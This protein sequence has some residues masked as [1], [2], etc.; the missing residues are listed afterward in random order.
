[1]AE[2]IEHFITAFFVAEMALRFRA[3]GY[4]PREFLRGWTLFD[5]V[6][7]LAA[8][9][10]ALPGGA[11]LRMARLGRA[12]KIVHLLRRFP[13]LR[14]LELGTVRKLGREQA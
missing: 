7:I 3:T 5:L 14:L 4:R 6:L 11:A 8:V 2:Q 9:L 10:P 1:M 13:Q 12:I